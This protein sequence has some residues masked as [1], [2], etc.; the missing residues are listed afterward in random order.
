M[1][2]NNINKLIESR[3][4]IV[5]AVRNKEMS[6]KSAAN[7]LGVTR[8]GL[9]KI[10]KRVENG[11]YTKTN[12]LGS[13][14]GPRSYKRVWNRTEEWIEKEVEKSWRQ[15]CVGVSNLVWILE[16][17]VGISLSRSTIYRIL[18]R[19]K[20]YEEKK[21]TRK[22]KDCRHYTKSYPGEEIQIDTTEPFGKSKGIMIVAIDDYSRWVSADLYHGNTSAN[23]AK[24]LYRLRHS[25]PFPIVSVRLGNGSE[26]QKDFV[27]ACKD[28]NINIIRNPPHSPQKNGKVERMHR[29]IEEECL[30]R[31]KAKPKEEM[32]NKYWLN[33]YL[34]WYNHL[35]RHSGYGMNKKRPI[36]R[37]EEW[38]LHH[39]NNSLDTPEVTNVNETVIRYISCFLAFN[40]SILFLWI[41]LN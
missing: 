32:R 16:D 13:K 26:F 18:I 10:K 33:R 27:K 4:R 8:Q 12:L 3:K 35:R 40:Y 39:L 6:V 25:L 28:L 1:T 24:F 21:K 41:S 37:I 14:P 36:E 31:V 34:A 19:R 15:Y 30:W 11:G 22:R 17:T 20:V 38:L 2:D 7:L 5:R 23:A 29:T 9:W